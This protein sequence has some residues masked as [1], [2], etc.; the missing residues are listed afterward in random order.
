MSEAPHM[1]MDSIVG[2]TDKN[3]EELVKKCQY[4]WE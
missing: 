4:H 1:K 3:R 2:N